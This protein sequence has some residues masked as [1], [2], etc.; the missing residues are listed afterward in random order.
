[1]ALLEVPANQESCAKQVLFLACLALQLFKFRARSSKLI[2]KWR[3]SPDETTFLGRG[4]SMMIYAHFGERT[5]RQRLPR[6]PRICTI[7]PSTNGLPN[8]PYNYHQQDSEPSSSN[9]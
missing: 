9:Y 8:W 2:C 6:R 7:T 4:P 1:M 3:R 5:T